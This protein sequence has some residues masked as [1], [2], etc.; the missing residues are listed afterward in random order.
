MSCGSVVVPDDVAYIL[1]FGLMPLLKGF[2]S[3]LFRAVLCGFGE[4]FVTS[5]S[6]ALVTGI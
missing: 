4:D 3:L 5:A 2:A 1:C 6:A